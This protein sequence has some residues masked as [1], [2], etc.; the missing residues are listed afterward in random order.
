MGKER[1]KRST[2]CSLYFDRHAF[3]PPCAVLAVF[4][5]EIYS[6]LK[7]VSVHL[8]QWPQADESLIDP[9]A[10]AAGELIKEITAAIRRYKSEH[11]WR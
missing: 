1:E 5:E 6:H 11:V 3:A 2:V 9:D 10:E 8:A 7:Q 4:S